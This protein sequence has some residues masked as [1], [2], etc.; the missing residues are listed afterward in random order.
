MRFNL[1]G[2]APV[3]LVRLVKLLTRLT[4]LTLLAGAVVRPLAAQSLGDVARQEEERR[5]N[6][7][8]P[9]KVLTN[10]D[11]GGPSSEASA[12][13]AGAEGEAG[14]NGEKDGEK[15]GQ[16]D[17]AKA[18]DSKEP[19]KDQK[20]WSDR[21]KQLQTALDRDQSY[22]SALQT[23]INSLNTDFV[24]RDDPAQKAVIEQNRQKALAELNRLKDQVVSDKKAIDDLNDEARR[25]GVPPGWLR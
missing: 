1:V 14:K 22:S 21:L 13:P 24:N 4:L 19:V 12:A 9:S 18:K 25:A 7:K 20:Y 2:T 3:R 23:Q 17:A 16:K 15:D 6:V 11:L 8:E 5:K 10:K